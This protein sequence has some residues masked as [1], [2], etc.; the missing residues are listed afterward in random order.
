M[1]KRQRVFSLIKKDKALLSF[2]ASSANAYDGVGS[3]TQF[4]VLAI[5]LLTKAPFSAVG[6]CL[7]KIQ[8]S[9]IF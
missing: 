5:F 1:F 9:A 8:V 2:V 4:M 3:K 7:L 6:F